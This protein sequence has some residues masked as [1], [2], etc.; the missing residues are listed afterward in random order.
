M[1]A[2]ALSQFTFDHLLFGRRGVIRMVLFE[3]SF[4]VLLGLK[5]NGRETICVLHERIIQ[6]LRV[7]PSQFVPPSKQDHLFVFYCF[8]SLIYISE[9]QKAS[10]QKSLEPTMEGEAENDQQQF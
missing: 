7:E 4:P 10:S 3:P 6:R 8:V 2:V 1:S 9:S 5:W